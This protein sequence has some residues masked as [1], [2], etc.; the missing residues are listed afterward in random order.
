MLEV[1]GAVTGRVAVRYEPYALE[2]YNGGGWHLHISYAPTIRLEDGG[3][4]REGVLVDDDDG[5]E[6]HTYHG[7]VRIW[8]EV[9]P[10]DSGYAARGHLYYFECRRQGDPSPAPR[11]DHTALE[12][13][14]DEVMWFWHT[15]ERL[16]DAKLGH[17]RRWIAATEQQIALQR[18]LH[19]EA[20][21]YQAQLT[22]TQP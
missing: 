8:A 6:P 12:R 9:D 3:S 11:R 2:Y 1:H 16:R 22:H 18:R 4:R 17:A 5:G 10:R 7:H 19:A 14:A 21:A 15:P 20:I 13:L